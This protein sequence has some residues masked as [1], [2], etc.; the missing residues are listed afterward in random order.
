[1]ADRDDIEAQRKAV[2]GA[3]VDPAEYWAKVERE[4]PERL[5]GAALSTVAAGMQPEPAPPPESPPGPVLDSVRRIA[6]LERALAECLDIAARKAR[7]RPV[8]IVE[9]QFVNWRE[10]DGTDVLNALLADGWAATSQVPCATGG[11][12][13]LFVRLR[14]PEAAPPCAPPLG[15]P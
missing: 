8:S 6:E 10:S 4:W 14:E 7:G 1:M 2:E 5:V 9:R 3:T 12:L 11:V 13:I 15:L